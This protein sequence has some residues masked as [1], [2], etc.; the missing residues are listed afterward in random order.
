MTLRRA[1][2]LALAFSALPFSVYPQDSI[3][4]P[5]IGLPEFIPGTIDARDVQVSPFG[6]RIA[7]YDTSEINGI[8]MLDAELNELWRVRLQA[9]WAGSWSGGNII[10]FLPDGSAVLLP[11]VR[12]E[13]DV[14]LC[15]PDTGEAISYID[16]LDNRVYTLAASPDGS[17]ILTA[18]NSEIVIWTRDG[19]VEPG[20]LADWRESLRVQDFGPGI[21][22]ARF[23]PDG[24]HL[25]LATGDSRERELVIYNVSGSSLQR[26]FVYGLSDGNISHQFYEIAISADGRWMVSAYRQRLFFFRRPEGAGPE[27]FTLFQE[28]PDTEP[29]SITTLGM[30]PDAQTVFTGHFRFIQ[31]FRFNG[32][33]WV[34]HD[35]HPT[36]QTVTRDIA[37]A[38]DG[39]SILVASH[40]DENAAARY[41][42]TGSGPDPRA[43]VVQA[44]GGSL[45]PAQRAVLT[46]PVARNLISGL[47][48]GSLAR[49]DL[50][51]TQKDYERRIE[52]AGDSLRTALA[53]Q[54]ETYWE[55]E[56]SDLPG[57]LAEIRIRLQERGTYDIDS[58]TY[59][60]SAMGSVFGVS[61]ERPIAQALYRNWTNA[62]LV[63]TRIPDP[64][65]ETYTDP[66]IRVPGFAD[67]PVLMDLHPLTG[68]R[69]NPGQ[70]RLSPVRIG[71]DL[72]ITELRLSAVTP[73]PAQAA[74]RA[75]LGSLV[76][77]NTGT[78]VISDV[79]VDLG[80]G[81]AEAQLQPV[82]APTTLAAGQS[83]P[84]ELT[85]DAGLLPEVM[86]QARNTTVRL[87]VSY[88]RGSRRTEESVQ[89]A[90][91]ILGRN[92]I[93]WD[94]DLRVGAFV[95]P[96][97][98]DLV[99]W[100]GGVIA[101]LPVEPSAALNRNILSAMALFE[102]LGL[103]GLR[104][105]VDPNSAY[106]ELST[107]AGAVDFLRFP[108][109]TLA[110][111]LGDC[112]DLSV[113]Y[114]SL[115]E[116]TGVATAFLTTPGHILVAVDSGIA[117]D[118]IPLL[119]GDASRF[120]L[121]EDKAWLPV[122]TTALGSPFGEA[123]EAGLSE[124]RSA[125]SGGGFFTASS[126]FSRYR[127]VLLDTPP[128]LPQSPAT[129]V[130]AVLPG[131]VDSLK[132]PILEGLLQ[133]AESDPRG[134]SPT[135]LNRQ[136]VILASWGELEE[137]LARFDRA[138]REGPSVPALINRATA[139]E[140]AGRREAARA[141]LEDALALDPGNARAL[142]GM[143]F[144]F[145]AEGNRADAEGWYRQ[146]EAASPFLAN[147]Y[148]LPDAGDSAE[149][150]RAVRSSSPIADEW[151]LD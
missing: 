48:P 18:S 110:S 53:L 27:A 92:A 79:R 138:I 146:F 123:W 137:A 10:D 83:V 148:P 120:I 69:L 12:T 72:S 43:A 97:A 142:L 15:D 140:R 151:T 6:Q 71:T 54:V 50:F 81:S 93:Q 38:P 24:E 62:R 34:R 22:A 96:E 143:A 29:G 98:P 131:R 4:L 73:T 14:C 94:D 60:T 90:L 56:R 126:A 8:R 55:A 64:A 135:G 115:L 129:A 128:R 89:Q 66:R 30:T 77:A 7:L 75:E 111:G 52:E 108:Q 121:R 106:E 88:R 28:I 9:Y 16:A 11:S 132:D 127:P 36:Q 82:T 78:G 23:L 46:S 32:Q 47:P 63:F 100:A 61:L 103:A 41:S 91:T 105:V 2:I 99:D 117:P 124:W 5:D 125:G 19:S 35:L 3:D 67:Y 45:A 42:L 118:A 112:D 95:Q 102:A 57:N 147:R 130:T 33:R 109:E 25:V 44:L 20:A 58:L 139:L 134:S 40:A 150:G 68:E 51:E 85:V 114:A 74:G 31:S 136:G 116:A 141:S 21:H 86:P 119:Y 17:R 113:L 80:F 87:R 37:V 59:T 122:E 101:E 145:W 76:L 1:R 133:S 149:T 49:R 70:Q 104:Y 144:S 13:G 26:V 84:L 107:Q 65:G 39:Q